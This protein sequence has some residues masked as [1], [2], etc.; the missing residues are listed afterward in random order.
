[1]HF[2][3]TAIRKSN[4]SKSAKFLFIACLFICTWIPIIFFIIVGSQQKINPNIESIKT[5]FLFLGVAHV[6]AT[7]FFYTEKNFQEVIRKNIAMFIYIPL[8]L[9]L[10][11]GIVFLFANKTIQ[12]YILFIYWVWQTYHY[13]RQNVGLYS[14]VSIAES[15]KSPSRLEKFVIELGIFCGILGTL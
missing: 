10:G 9:T 13:G 1:M 14:F 11:T 8:A 5:M 6:P 4:F 12:A 3:L 2:D 7:L 15:S